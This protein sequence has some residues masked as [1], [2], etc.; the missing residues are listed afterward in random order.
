MSDTTIL[1]ELEPPLAT[2]RL[3]RPGRMNAVDETL[4]R[5]L[6]AALARCVADERTRCIVLTGSVLRRGGEAKPAFC[7]GAD[8]KRHAAGERDEEEQRTY[9]RL[10][11]ATALAVWRCPKPVIAAVNG[12]A[13]GAGTELALACDFV[14][15]AEGATLG[16]PE[17]RLGTFVGGGVT[18]VLPRLVGLTRAKEL[19]YTGAVV[20]AH[21]A[22]ELGLALRACPLAELESA[23]RA[24]ALELAAAAPL[25]L[26]LAKQH[27]QAA[28]ERD[29]E[30][31][32]AQEQAAILQCMQTRDWH[33]G[34]RAFAERR[35]PRFEGR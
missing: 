20:D 26:A 3:H 28:S 18:H 27:L 11:H 9:I 30:H 34:V 17:I 29:I 15:M 23:A 25:P 14:L 16:L 21:R 33:E 8:L 12:P 7:A 5:E 32:L 4:Y 13:R 35:A 1:L 31:A 2:I 19:V 24:L 22:V 6:A 10:A